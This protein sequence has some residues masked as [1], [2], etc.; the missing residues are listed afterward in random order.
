MRFRT[1][2]G[3]WFPLLLLAA[4][5]AFVPPGIGRA[6]PG[7]APKGGE[8]G[9]RRGAITLKV[10][11][12]TT[13]YKKDMATDHPKAVLVTLL[14]KGRAIR[15]RELRHAEWV[16]WKGLPAGAY[17][18]HVEAEGYARC[19]KHL[20]LSA[21]DKD[22]RVHA[23]VG[24]TPLVLGAGASLEEVLARLRKLE[25]KNAELRATVDQVR[26]DIERLK[27]K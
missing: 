21:E 9:S 8:E 15:S 17:E 18:L 13:D 19:V 25:E 16:N 2:R 6:R 10:E 27:K 5:T 12:S 23:L 26:K 1:R 3:L 20:T 11:Y 14:S 24:K 22:M 7:S 4:V